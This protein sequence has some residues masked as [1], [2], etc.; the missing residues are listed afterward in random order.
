MTDFTT[1]IQSIQ[2]LVN[3][4]ESVEHAKSLY[5]IMQGIN[6]DKA[7]ADKVFEDML[8]VKFSNKKIKAQILRMEEKLK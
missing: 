1:E 3:T 7:V 6:L 5:H 8:K 2:Y 4:S